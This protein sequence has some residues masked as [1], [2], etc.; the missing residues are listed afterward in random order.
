MGLSVD[1]LEKATGL[2]S[3]IIHDIKTN[4]NNALHA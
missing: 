2:E 1:Q 4:K 3:S